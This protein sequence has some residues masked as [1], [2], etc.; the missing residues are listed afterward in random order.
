MS[1]RTSFFAE[2]KRRHVYRVAVAYVIVGWLLIQFATS[3]FPALSLPGWATTLVVLLIAIGF[4]I[5]LIFAWA[6]ELTP[7]GIRRTEPAHSPEARP[8]EFTQ[9]VGKQLNTI[10]IGVMAIVIVLLL[11]ERFLVHKSGSEATSAT[12]AVPKDGA[13]ATATAKSIAVMPFANTSG[14]PGNE[15]FSDGMSEELINALGR[16][17]DLTVI[18]RSSSFQFK[19]RSED[20]RSIG[21]KLGVAYLLEGSVRKAEDKVRIAVELVNAGSGADVWSETYDRDLNDIFAVQSEIA[22]QVAGKLNTTLFGSAGAA[23]RELKPDAPP[24]GN[25]AAYNAALQGNFY[26]ERRTEKDLRRAIEFYEQATQL[27]SRYALA[28]ARLAF[29]HTDL[30]ASFIT[31]TGD[32]RA[33]LEAEVRNSLATA[34]E[35]DP[36]LPDAHIAQ[37]YAMEVL[38]LNLSGAIAEYER[39]GKLAPQNPAAG[40]RLAVT[41][42]YIGE[43]EAA[44]AGLHRVLEIDP[45]SARTHYYLATA[46]VGS[47]RYAEAE[48]TVRKAIELQPQ[49]GVQHAYLAIT[50]ILQGRSSDALAAAQAETDPFWRTYALA[51]AHSAHGDQAEGD[52]ALQKLIAEDAD[53]AGSQIAQVYALRKQPDEAFKWLDHAYETH[54]GGL[55]QMRLGAFLGPYMKDP[56]FE[57]IAR[58]AHVWTDSHP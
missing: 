21:A 24:S 5:A 37:G 57:A 34:L 43:F 38:D 50:L 30:D 33:T 47:G 4:P 48:A 10:I 25:V 46:L 9:R 31:T 8:A 49:A 6:F 3:V 42:S 18:G 1:E 20:A 55:Q 44:I 28:Y 23:A 51:L 54:D 29:A 52:A 16:L 11:A 12:G 15:Y 39:A 41:R 27:D 19:G 53:D 13:P 56:R 22:K 35:V 58:K 14:D 2:L 7:E 45:L 17:K 26:L 40:L 36:D 32:A